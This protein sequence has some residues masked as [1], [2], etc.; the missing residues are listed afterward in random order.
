MESSA[1]TLH[2]EDASDTDLPMPLRDDLEAIHL[3][4][5]IDDLS[6][7]DGPNLYDIPESPTLTQPKPGNDIWNFE[8]GGPGNTNQQSTIGR[9]PVP[10]RSPNLQRCRLPSECLRG[11]KVLRLPPPP[12]PPPRPGLKKQVSCDF[13]EPLQRLTRSKTV[14]NQ[15]SISNTHCRQKA[16]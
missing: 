11:E 5:S 12:P 10:P 14:C 9:P 8:I 6:Q 1:E 2:R 7:N 15:V 16:P 4:E 13:S 3:Y